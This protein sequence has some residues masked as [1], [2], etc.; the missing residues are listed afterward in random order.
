MT[1]LLSL[2]SLGIGV[3]SLLCERLS[4][5]KVEI[6]L[7]PFGSIGL[8]VFGIDLFFAKSSMATG[9]IMNA[10]EFF[11]SAGSWRVMIDLALIGLFGGFYIVPL[12]ALVQQR[13]EPSH[14]SRIIAA[15]NILNALF[16]VVSALLVILLLKTG[17]SI[18]Q[19]FLVFGIFNAFVAIYI[20]SLVPEFLMRFIVWLLI[21]TIYRV[22]EEGL[23][24]IPE[25]GAAVLVCNHVSYVDALVIA[26]ASRRP[27]RFVIH[28][29]IYQV[30]VLNFVFRTARTI[31][32]AGYREDPTM[33]NQAYDEISA[34]L[35][36][37]ELVCIF[38]E[39]KVTRDGELGEFKHGIEKAIKRDPVPVIPM[40]LR[41]LWGSVFSFKHGSI[42]RILRCFTYKMG[43]VV[44]ESISPEEIS[45]EKLQQEVLKLR[46]NWK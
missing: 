33:L 28:Y 43:F 14:R 4:R 15:N 6:G 17:L 16:M 24:K 12:Y 25:K 30:P 36:A 22:Q 1:I 29:K 10:V 44:G 18:P 5:N 20:Y 41:G 40:A 21:H 45:A 35:N 32:I 23:E 31:P 37:G 42:L 13:S 7:V 11:W 27:V 34:A 3:G 19:L 9:E 2:F 39:G 26:G 8:T 46:G 38:P